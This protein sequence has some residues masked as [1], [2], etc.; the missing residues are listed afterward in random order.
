MKLYANSRPS[1]GVAFKPWVDRV[2]ELLEENNI[3]FPSRHELGDYYHNDLS[4]EEVLRKE[5]FKH[6]QNVWMELNVKHKKGLFNIHFN[7][8]EQ[9]RDFFKKF[10]ELR[11]ELDR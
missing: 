5:Q 10:P 9:A 3:D 4:Y 2:R 7:T 11:K 1:H 6:F 8:T